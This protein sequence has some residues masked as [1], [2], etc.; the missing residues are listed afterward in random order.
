MSGSEIINKSESVSHLIE[1]GLCS[2][3]AIRSAMAEAARLMSGKGEANLVSLERIF[4]VLSD[5][6]R[7][8][9]L[10]LLV[11]R[12]MCVCE[13]MSA[14]KLSQPTAS[15]N[16]N[17]LERVGLVRRRRKGKWAF[18]AISSSQTARLVRRLLVTGDK[19]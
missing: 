19:K 1:D 7:I 18:Y 17:M 6:N 15:R 3:S 13:I 2:L 9:I 4:K 14:M 12:E 10:I 11:N 16:M 5:R 8:A